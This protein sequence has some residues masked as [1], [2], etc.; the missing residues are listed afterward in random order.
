MLSL[1]YRGLAVPWLVL[2]VAASTMG[3]RD[4]GGSVIA[5][6]ANNY[7][8]TVAVDFVAQE[9]TQGENATIDWSGLTTDM[10]GNP[11]VPGD[12]ELV[13]LAELALTQEEALEK[14]AAGELRSSDI[15]TPWEFDNAGG[16]TSC[17][18]TDFIVQGNNFNPA[19][20]EIGFFPRKADASWTVS[21]WRENPK[22]LVFEILSSAF[23]VPVGSSKE[24]TLFFAD[25]TAD[26]DFTVD[27]HSSEPLVA[28]GGSPD[29]IMDWE[30]LVNDA[31][32][33]EFDPLR[34]TWLFIARIPDVSDVT[35][36]EGSLLTELDDAETWVLD[37]FGER[38]A[39]LSQALSPVTAGDSFPGFDNDG[40]W[41]VGI[42]DP[43]GNDPS[44]FFMSVI[45]VQ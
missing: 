6:D 29:Q 22:L 14:V 7:A 26:L 35:A 34:A 12:V 37:V 31:S 19:D 23:L 5:T 17:E 11:M 13:R 41:L 27:L 9:L 30:G 10:R 43:T 33:R 25:D 3:C 1:S 44:P 8:F 16:A 20:G 28:S 39:D 45:T 36:L 42:M 15:R 4:K 24:D 40:T 38:Q 21:L 18:L 2:A 32:G